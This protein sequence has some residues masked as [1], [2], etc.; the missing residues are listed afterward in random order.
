MVCNNNN[1]YTKNITENGEKKTKVCLPSLVKRST[2]WE[3]SAL[4]FTI[5]KKLLQE[6]TD[7]LQENGL[8]LLVPKNNPEGAQELPYFYP[9]VSQPLQPSIYE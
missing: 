6:I 9:S 8:H 5:L 4:Q 3:K 1:T 2:P 7:E